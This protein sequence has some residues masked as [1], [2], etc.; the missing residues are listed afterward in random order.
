M[1][2][3]CINNKPIPGY[4]NNPVALSKISEGEEYEGEQRWMEGY[5]IEGWRIP[6]VSETYCYT[7]SR[8]IPLPDA[9]ADE[10]QEDTREAIVNLETELV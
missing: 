1:R 3:Y 2:L 7:L 10:M 6:S 4:H 5:R 9:T 8:F